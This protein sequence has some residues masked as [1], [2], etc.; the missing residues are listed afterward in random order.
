[1]VFIGELW[2]TSKLNRIIFKIEFKIRSNGM[3]SVNFIYLFD[4]IPF[5]F[6]SSSVML[7]LYQSNI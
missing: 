5:V 2:Q 6:K 3:L 4:D 7:Y 1:M